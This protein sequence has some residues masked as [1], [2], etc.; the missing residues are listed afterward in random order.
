MTSAH[1]SKTWKDLT[2]RQ[3]VLAAAVISTEVALTTTAL[4]DL[5]RRPRERVRGPKL[6]WAAMCFVQPFG[7]VAYL[8]V[9]RRR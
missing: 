4:V 1:R 2:P 3:K 9:H 7:P 5:V 6:A 8:L